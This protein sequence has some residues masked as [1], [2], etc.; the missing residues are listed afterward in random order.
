MGHI[1]NYSNWKD[2]PTAMSLKLDESK[3]ASYK[4]WKTINEQE[5]IGKK[6]EKHVD[7]LSDEMG[8]DPSEFVKAFTK[9]INLDTGEDHNIMGKVSTDIQE[10]IVESFIY[11]KRTS[12]KFY[13]DPMSFK[14]SA[15]PVKAGKYKYDGD[16]VK[17]Q[18]KHITGLSK[19][20][21]GIPYIDVDGNFVM[22]SQDDIITDINSKN[23]DLYSEK[24]GS[25]QYSLIRV[26]QKAKPNGHKYVLR[27]GLVENA[28]ALYVVAPGRFQPF[29][30]SK[31]DKEGVKTVTPGTEAS[32]KV[33]KFNI[34]LDT[35]EGST[36]GVNFKTESSEVKGTPVD[37]IY[38]A[39]V[40]QAKKQGVTDM[41]TLKITKFTIVSSASNH[42]GGKLAATHNNAGQATN[43]A[44]NTPVED[45]PKWSAKNADSNFTLAKTRGTN[46]GA[47]L[48]P[49]LK[50]KGIAEIA[51]PT[52]SPRVTDTGGVND[53]K[54]NTQTHPNGGQ[55]AQLIIEA[56]AT[57]KSK[58]EIPGT[59]E[60]TKETKEFTQ[61]ALTLAD[62]S[63]KGKGLARFSNF[64][65]SR[66]KYLKKGG[67]G[68]KSPGYIGRHGGGNRPT[69]GLAGWFDGLF[70][71]GV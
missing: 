59:P 66:P 3:I 71:S 12:K 38:S 26:D 61:F 34:K 39:L 24:K 21:E 62:G 25:S 42:W 30:G 60:K 37:S 9:K 67:K 13:K 20:G 68:W 18:T 16:I 33:L 5:D 41:S 32:V 70:Y 14:F 52:S 69:S 50:K 22:A 54:R 44:H 4:N 56:S 27:A 31:M 63:G 48:L 6:K 53:D 57:G 65:L 8:M 19:N 46:L 1:D 35:N 47:I 40:E 10:G 49:G 29:T 23:A 64:G 28:Y 2:K 17:D 51:A 11:S 58:E 43:V 45:N 55:Y 15:D 7:Q 36:S